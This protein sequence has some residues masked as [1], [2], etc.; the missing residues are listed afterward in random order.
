MALRRAKAYLDLT[1]PTIQLLVVLTGAAALVYDGSLLLRPERFALAL[2]ALALSA[3][4]AK[5]LN[6][7]IERH[8]DARMERTR[9]SRPLPRGSIAPAEALVFALILGIVATALF[10]YF[11]NP[12]SAILAVAT[13]SFY[14]LFYTLYLK[15]NT[16]FSIVIGGI[17]GSM[18]PVISWAAT[19]SPLS[20]VTLLMFLVVFCW[21]PPHFWAL[22]YCHQEDFKKAGYP[23]LP[24]MVSRQRFWRLTWLGGAMTLVASLAL[25]F[26]GAGIRYLAIASISGIIFLRQI[27]EAGKADSLEKARGVFIYSMVYLVVLFAALIV[28]RVM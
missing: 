27:R 26:V 8:V 14:S 9:F 21:T 2:F 13:I 1:K 4:S 11:F 7:Y 17:A 28:D 24:N 15:P 16:P 10:A 3:G 5:A 20:G 25:G 12:L 18:G 22:A 6:Q 23:M 19:G